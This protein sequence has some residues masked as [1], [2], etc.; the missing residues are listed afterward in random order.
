M[1]K[2]QQPSG[3]K[4]VYFRL[5][6]PTGTHLAKDIRKFINYT[7]EAFF[8]PFH[9]IGLGIMALTTATAMI[10][11]TNLL[12]LD[13]T[14]LLFIFGGLEMVF[15]SLITRSRR[16]RRAINFKYRSQLQAYAY[17]AKLTEYYNSLSAKGQRR[18]EEFRVK[19]HETKSN[20][21]RLNES[22]PELVQQYQQK[23]DA[24]QLNYIRLLA[25]FDSFPALLKQDDPTTL[26]RE[27]EE[28]RGGMGDDSPKLREIKEKRI[29][30]LQDRIRNHHSILEN[31]K[32]IE[33][34]LRTMEEM[35]KYLKE[36]PLASKSHEG[37]SMIDNLLNETNDLHATLSQVEEIMRSD[38]R[39]HDYGD[40][41]ANGGSPYSRDEIR[42]E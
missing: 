14:G 31:V 33:E 21:L 39:G 20:Y 37:S 10:L 24:L 16:F 9:L 15:L 3:G 6:H 7:K 2:N 8:W 13:V 23:I 17:V 36:Q 26:R 25:S 5:I 22:F 40:L 27:I 19:L 34:Q 1:R 38:L 41:N 29:K 35:I 18:F 42:V 12:N 30:L 32:V 11:G 4:G 28:I